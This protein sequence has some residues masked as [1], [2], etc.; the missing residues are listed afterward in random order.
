MHAAH[1]A[2][3]NELVA[4]AAVAAAAV[5]E[6]DNVFAVQAAPVD[7]IALDGMDLE[8]GAADAD[9]I[10]FDT[11]LAAVHVDTEPLTAWAA[12]VV[13]LPVEE[14]VEGEE[15]VAPLVM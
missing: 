13:E 11:G 14:E 9:H 7:D 4:A 3:G 8:A 12:A 15:V 2:S 6:V 10:A 1:A 5:L